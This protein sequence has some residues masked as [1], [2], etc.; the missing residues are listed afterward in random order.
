MANGL[1]DFVRDFGEGAILGF[2][3][4][5]A[6]NLERRGAEDRKLINTRINEMNKRIVNGLAKEQQMKTRIKDRLQRIEAEVPNLTKDD[7]ISFA[8]S[9]EQFKVLEQKIRDDAARDI[10]QKG[11]WYK[12]VTGRNPYEK[13]DTPDDIAV[14]MSEVFPD[15]PKTKAP[16]G[17]A[18]DEADATEVLTAL[19]GAPTDPAKLAEISERKL[20][21]M[22]GLGKLGGLPA[23]ELELYYARG[24]QQRMPQAGPAT[25]L[26][27]VQEKKDPVKFATLTQDEGAAIQ[28][29]VNIASDTMNPV[30]Q[31]QK[32]ILDAVKRDVEKENQKKLRQLGENSAEYKSFKKQIEKDERQLQEENPF[33][34][35]QRFLR[36]YAALKT[37]TNDKRTQIKQRE[38]IDGLSTLDKIILD[39]IRILEPIITRNRKTQTDLARLA[40]IIEKVSK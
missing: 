13:T 26:A 7:K 39:R 40:N 2:G 32:A 15:L 6:E 9:D 20:M 35:Q 17:K 22:R 33:E 3:Q 36:A 5:V 14:L 30:S 11:L 21:T 10:D 37:S 1:M 29:I 23:Q 19:F 27:Q 8:A 18:A 12:N 25:T 16:S 31:Y 4:G 24:G 34:R 38:V 28:Q